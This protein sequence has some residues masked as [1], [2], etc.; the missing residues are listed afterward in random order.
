[1]EQKTK[2]T[3]LLH[4]CCGPC[5]S[6]CLERL[7]PDY[8]ITVFYYNPNITDE[9]EYRMREEELKH[10]LQRWQPEGVPTGITAQSGRYDPQ[11]YYTC[12][13]GLEQE[14]EGGARC[15]ACF[16]LRLEETAKQA[17]QQGFDAFDT[18]LSVSPYKNSKVLAEIGRSLAAKY[19]VEYLEGNYKKQDGY[20]RSIEL[21][22]EY[23]LYR[24]DYCGCEFSKA[25]AEARRAAKAAARAVEA[26]K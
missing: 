21:S 17:A 3:L 5:S 22:R 26:A 7:Y 16:L 20:R 18:T 10:F 14:P 24:Q 15:R 6:A 11:E 19:G 4:A 8:D 23:G 1:M 12:V 13:K 2:K 25:E 9:G